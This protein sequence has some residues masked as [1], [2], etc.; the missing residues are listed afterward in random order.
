MKNKFFLVLAVITA[1]T[2]FYSLPVYRNSTMVVYASEIYSYDDVGYITIDNVI[3]NE[4]ESEKKL[5]DTEG[6]SEE[7]IHSFIEP[8]I[9]KE[10]ENNSV[11]YSAIE[12]SYDE[13]KYIDSTDITTIYADTEFNSDDISAEVTVHQNKSLIVVLSCAILILILICGFVIRR[14]LYEHHK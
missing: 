14:K 13:D 8:D 9:A 4:V 11:D 6:N 10:K 7:I 12:N 3:G 5:E 1:S 2:I